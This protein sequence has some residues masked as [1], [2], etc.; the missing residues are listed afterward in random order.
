MPTPA[1]TGFTTPDSAIVA[2]QHGRVRGVLDHGVFAFKGVPYGAPTSGARRFRPP[3]PPEPWTGVRNAF[4]FGPICPQHVYG[5]GARPRLLDMPQYDYSDEDCLVLNVWTPGVGDGVRRPVMVWLHGGAFLMG[6]ANRP[7]TWGANLA[8]RRDV[9]VVSVHHR[10]HALGHLDL[11]AYGDEYAE[12]ANVGMLDI[13]AALRWVRD[14]IAEFGGDPA[15]VTVFGQSGGGAKVA[16]LLAM[17]A[18]R[19]LFH[20]AI[21]QSSSGVINDA[22]KSE[23]LSAR[24]LDALGITAANLHLLEEL[25]V[26]RLVAAA[27][28]VSAAPLNPGDDWRPKVDGVTILQKPFDGALPEPAADVP[29]MLGGARHEFAP[30]PDHGVLSDAEL[31]AALEHTLEPEA[32]AQLVARLREMYPGIVNNELLAL[33]NVQPFRASHMRQA[34][35]AAARPGAATYVYNFAW[36]SPNFDGLPLAYHGAELPFVFANVAECAP[37]TGDSPEAHAL[38]DLMSA[39]WTSFARTGVPDA[40]PVGPWEPFDPERGNTMVFDTESG[41][42]D[43]PWQAETELILAAAGGMFAK[44]SAAAL[45]HR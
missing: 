20:R 39:A 33:V 10:L 26:E 30:E 15:C 6:T 42:V 17:P 4:V 13:V 44:P 41:Q 34:T 1:G 16:T 11:S 38:A 40:G 21:V 43:R 24:F 45:L 14:N 36:K 8:R 12:S 28:E 25:P 29:I 22:E 35:L 32:A 27:T 2:T 37:L 5:R 31:H 23:R 19:G 7:A 18:A 9:V 3:A